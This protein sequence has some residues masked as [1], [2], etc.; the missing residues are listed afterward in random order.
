MCPCPWSPGLFR[1]MIIPPVWLWA[2][3]PSCHTHASFCSSDPSSGQD[4][5]GFIAGK[6]NPISQGAVGA[7]HQRQTGNHLFLDERLQI[8]TG[9]NGGS[10]HGVPAPGPVAVQTLL[11]TSPNN[12]HLKQIRE[13]ASSFQISGSQSDPAAPVSP[14]APKNLKFP[15]PTWDLWSQKLRGGAPRILSSQDATNGA[16]RGQQSQVPD[17]SHPVPPPPHNHLSLKPCPFN[18]RTTP[19]GFFCD[20]LLS[21]EMRLQFSHGFCGTRAAA[22]V[23][24]ETV[25]KTSVSTTNIELS[26]AGSDS[27]K[28]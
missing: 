3:P 27:Q 2:T 5:P 25:G 6:A 17:A 9:G 12:E 21:S 18:G 28:Q 15:D 4:L 7:I 13:T 26:P 16:V 1:E 23:T 19:G 10:G 14:G 11:L 22:A 8:Y 24:D 20:V